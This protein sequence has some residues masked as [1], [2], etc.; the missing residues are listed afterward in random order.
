MTEGVA[1]QYRGEIESEAVHVHLLDPV[2]KTVQDHAAHNW[3]ICIQ[4]VPGAAVIGVPGTILLKDVVGAVI[5][6]AVTQ[7]W[8]AVVALGSVIEHDIENDFDPR[9]V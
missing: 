6:S 5:Y 2:P 9:A 1:C 3:V 8:T 7:C 4:R